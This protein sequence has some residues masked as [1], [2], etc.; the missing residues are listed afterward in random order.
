MGSGTNIAPVS[1]PLAGLTTDVTYHFRAAASNSLGAVYGSDQSFTA[2][3][4][5][6][7]RSCTEAALRAA[8]AGGGTVSFACDGTIPLA[9]TVMVAT[10]TVLDALG[11]KS[12][13]VA[14][15]PSGYSTSPT[16]LL[17]PWPT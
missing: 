2:R 13:S 10:D 17:F 15:A 8:M 16:T 1:I 12:R 3:D 5:G 7:V 4:A 14:V 9:S 11:T 6:I